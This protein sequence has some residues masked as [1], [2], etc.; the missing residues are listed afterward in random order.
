MLLS[1]CGNRGIARMADVWGSYGDSGV[2]WRRR[3]WGEATP[4]VSVI[5]R[6]SVSRRAIPD[7]LDLRLRFSEKQLRFK[8][9]LAKCVP[10]SFP[11][12][13]HSA[14]SARKNPYL[15]IYIQKEYILAWLRKHRAVIIQKEAYHTTSHTVF[16]KLQVSFI[17]LWFHS[18][19]MSKIKYRERNATNSLSVYLLQ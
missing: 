8:N 11:C 16:E 10:G 17:R 19:S 12:Q 4:L 5:I 1:P 14:P 6:W 3:G 15:S 9:P 2:C 13:D 7:D 18:I